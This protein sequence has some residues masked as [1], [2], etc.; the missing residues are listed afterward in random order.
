M[1]LHRKPKEFYCPVCGN[2][3]V[4]GFG[5]DCAFDTC[6]CEKCGGIMLLRN[7]TKEETEGEK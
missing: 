5:V 7:L 4:V 3:V 1:T 2:D 6:E